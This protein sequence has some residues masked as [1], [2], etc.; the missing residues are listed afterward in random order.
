VG[1]HK[2]EHGNSILKI[3]ISISAQPFYETDIKGTI[4][5]IKIAPLL[6]NPNEVTLF[7]L[8]FI[9]LLVGRDH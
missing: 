9:E 7:L 1:S 5:A 4:A 6:S 8:I 2:G 3:F